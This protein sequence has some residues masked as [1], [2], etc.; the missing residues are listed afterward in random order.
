MR[1]PATIK[2][3]A[4]PMLDTN[5]AASI[6]A[7]VTNAPSAAP[8]LLLRPYAPHASYIRVDAGHKRGGGIVHRH[9]DLNESSLAQ[10][11]FGLR[12]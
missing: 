9:P 1:G 7:T 3:E 5:I 8:F 11:I 10:G 6:N 4:G 2:A 12:I